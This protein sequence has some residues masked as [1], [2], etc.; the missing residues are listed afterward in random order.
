MSFLP[1]SPLAWTDIMI[2]TLGFSLSFLLSLFYS[3]ERGFLSLSLPGPLP[4]QPLHTV[5]LFLC[6]HGVA[7][8]LSSVP[9][10]LA[11][12]RSGR[13]TQS[14]HQPG[15]QNTHT[16]TVKVQHL[17][18][19]RVSSTHVQI[20]VLKLIILSEEHTELNRASVQ[21]SITMLP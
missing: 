14:L 5:T 11:I 13:P 7:S 9:N 4:V 2:S 3:T 18:F 6:S 8:K 21:C 12:S 10:K 17:F 1:K 15:L 19:V 20:L 16:R